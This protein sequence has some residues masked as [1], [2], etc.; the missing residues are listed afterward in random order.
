MDAVSYKEDAFLV[1]RGVPARSH[2]TV[3][4]VARR[5]PGVTG[6]SRYA[7]SLLRALRALDLKPECIESGVGRLTGKL[8]R[9]GQ[10]LGVDLDT[11]FAQ[12]PLSLR[13]HAVDVYHLTSQNLATLLVFQRFDRPVVVTVHDIIPWLVR[14]DRPLNT[15]RHAAHRGFDYLALQGL[16]R[17]DVLISDS[18]WTKEMLVQ[19][20][21][22][23]AERIR[24]IHLGIDHTRF[25]PRTIPD[26][27]RERHGLVAGRRFILYVGSEDPRK[28]LETLL[29]AFA[30]IHRDRPDVHLLKV[31]TPHHL[32]EHARLRAL[33][34]DL[35]VGG[36][37]RWLD[38]VPE[39]ELAL[40][41]GAA[42]VLVLPS[43]YEGF[44]LPALEAMACGTP[45]VCSNRASLP[46]VVGDGALLCAP[47]ASSLAQ[48][49]ARV[50]DDRSFAAEVAERGCRRAEVMTWRRTAE[51]TIGVYENVV[52][53]KVAATCV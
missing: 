35:G 29:H 52:G 21:H 49:M 26:D 46:E 17:A 33:A 8:T 42:A 48:A 50:L 45:V 11:F 30:R 38:H 15:Y 16:R 51:E 40:F 32:A 10:K 24:V 27:V 18:Q 5:E 28:N 41:Y 25:H 1:K 31:G 13:R 14:R 53:R 37:V 22:I 12:Y 43:L 20:L 2:L 34:A 36:A 9:L 7:E 19:E 3:G 4:L 47:D 44:G 23:P 39:A 6:T